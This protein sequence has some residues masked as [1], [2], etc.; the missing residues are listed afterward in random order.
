VLPRPLG[1]S[2]PGI[3]LVDLGEAP[4][5]RDTWIGYHRDLRRLPRLRALFDLIVQRL[6]N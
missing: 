4:P 3:V 6:A 1:D 5:S 2:T